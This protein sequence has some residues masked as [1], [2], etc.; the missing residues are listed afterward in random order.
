MRSIYRTQEGRAAVRAA[1]AAILENWPV[2]E[3]THHLATR[4]GETFVISSGP[5][6]APPLVLLHGSASNSAMWL[7]DV[8]A[9]SQHFHVHAVDVIGEPG[10]SAEGRPALASGI[11]AEWLTD[12][13]AGLEIDRAAFVGVSLGGWLGL[14]FATHKPERVEKLVLLA[15]GGVGRHKNVLVWALPLLMLGKW[16]R[17]RLLRRIGGA[18]ISAQVSAKARRF[19]AFM[20][21]IHTHFRPRTERLPRFSDSDLDRLTMPVLAVLGGRDVFIDSAG[22]RGRLERHVRRL[23]MRYLPEGGHFLPGQTGPILQFLADAGA[24]EAPPRPVAA[25][26]LA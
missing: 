15:P 4:H 2:P 7:G 20:H 12:V 1:Y 19:A 24:G 14:D 9:W 8:A 25:V 11:Y 21:L 3:R 6:D 18:H 26:A 10:L 22:T 23:D 13:L 5:V 17:E 16:G